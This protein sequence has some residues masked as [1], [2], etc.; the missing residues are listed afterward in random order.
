[1][2]T[3]AFAGSGRI[4]VVHGLAAQAL[5][6]PVTYVA[7]RNPTHASERAHQVGAEA[8]GYDDLPADADLVVVA[9]PPARH[10]R[11]ALR[12]LRGGAAVLVEKP[13]CTTLAEAD[14]LVAAAEGRVVYGEN[15]AFAPVITHATR[16]TRRLGPLRHLEARAIQ[17]RP[18]WGDFLQSSWGGGA[19]FDL[20]VHPLALVLL[21][22][23]DTRPV[24]VTARLETAADIEVDEFAELTLQFR[25][26]LVATV[27]TSW[28]GDDVVWDLQAA[29]DT[30]VVRAELLPNLSLEHNGEAVELPAPRY[31][32]DTPQLEQFGYVAQLVEAAKAAAG[33]TIVV[34]AAFGRAV[35]DVVCAAYQ[36]AGRGGAPEPLPFTG[37]RQHNPLELWRGA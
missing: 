13:L 30:G 19:L 21:L 28:R 29:S 26:G 20:G 2:P 23:G 35:L 8:G 25:S 12:S 32:P 14:E 34:D 4:T 3:V 6:F 15:L 9:T 36:S 1:M 24:S 5:Q 31:S 27:V 10:V 7:S 11:D 37:S 16:L 18:D 17:G 22:A 33:D